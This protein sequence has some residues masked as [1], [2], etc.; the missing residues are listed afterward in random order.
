MIKKMIVES[1]RAEP[2]INAANPR[3]AFWR[4]KEGVVKLVVSLLFASGIAKLLN[5]LANRFVCKRKADDS[6]Q[7]PFLRRRRTGNLQILIYHRVNDEK[8]PFFPGVP[9]RV[10]QAQMEYL[11]YNYCTLDL[12]EAVERL[13]RRDIPDNAIVI[14]FDDGYRDNYTNAFP[15]L[16]SLSLPATVFLAVD[17]IGSRRVLWHDRVFS[18]FRETRVSVLK[19]FDSFNEYPL[20]TVAERLLAQ[21]KALNFI[22]SLD[23]ELRIS[24]INSLIGKLEVPDRKEV[25]GLMLSWKEVKAMH[26]GGISFGSH[27]VTHPILSKLPLERI[28]EE[29]ERA[30]QLIEEKL[31]AR[32]RTFAYPNGRRSDFNEITKR[33]LRESGHVC[34]LTTNFG[35]NECDQDVFE[36][37]RA[38]PW[39]YHVKMFC[40]RLNYYKLCS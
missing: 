37:R 17:A 35:T 40:L 22:R 19:G 26:D 3:K 34:A 8:D 28:R 24:A 5:G 18:A 20:N 1:F 38:T 16:K 11:A 27:T 33:V 21:E 4:Y 13:R 7:F 9:L 14:T 10:F 39:D 12:E 15:V 6:L 36:L 23:E 2:I 25:A 31:G 29:I 32:V 30:R